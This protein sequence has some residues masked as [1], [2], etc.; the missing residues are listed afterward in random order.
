MKTT[1]N[2]IAIISQPHAE[3]CSVAVLWKC[4]ELDY[5]ICINCLTRIQLFTPKTILLTQL[6]LDKH[7]FL[8]DQRPTLYREVV[9]A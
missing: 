1:T 9:N 7:F 2:L 4:I 5:C 8:L 6:L 3:I